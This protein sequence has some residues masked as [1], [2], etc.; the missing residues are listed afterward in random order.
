MAYELELPS[1]WRIHN[2]FHV[3]LLRPFR[4]SQWAASTDGQPDDVEPEDDQPYEVERLLRWRWRGPS[5]R[6]H[7]EF[8]VLWTGWSIDDASWIPSSN[9]TH[10]EELKKMIQRDNPVEDQ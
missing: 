10:P 4:I 3:S 6:R 1:S 7:K 8:L 9:F 5:S 2:I